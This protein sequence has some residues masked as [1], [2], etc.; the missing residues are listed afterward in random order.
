MSVYKKPATPPIEGTPRLLDCARGPM[1]ELGAAIKA[2]GMPAYRV[3]E[4]V[5]S[6]SRRCTRSKLDE[7]SRKVP[8]GTRDSLTVSV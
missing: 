3:V 1:E 2:A 8:R 5:I 7:A 4:S 6:E